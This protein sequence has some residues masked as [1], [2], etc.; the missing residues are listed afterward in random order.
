MKDDIAL[1]YVKYN[2]L[3][4]II[5]KDSPEYYIVETVLAKFLN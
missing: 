3:L 5:I 4:R 2:V 1:C